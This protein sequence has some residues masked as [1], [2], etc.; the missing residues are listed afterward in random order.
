ML[1]QT[2]DGRIIDTLTGKVEGR[3]EGAPTTTSLRSGRQEQIVPEGDKVNGILR[4]A[5]WGLQS[6][7]FVAP[8]AVTLNIGKAL[9]M[10]E[11][12]VFTLGKFFKKDV[13]KALVGVEET[14]P[15]NANERFARALFE[16]IGGAMPFTG[17]VLWAA[18]AL[19]A[20]KTVSTSKTGVLRGVANETLNFTR[21]N[22]GKAVA[23]DLAFGAAY[24]GLRQAVTETISDDNPNKEAY[25]NLL[26]MAAFI[27]LPLATNFMPSVLVGKKIKQGLDTLEESTS[28]LSDA[29][30][31]AYEQ[32]GKGFKLPIINIAPKLLL[33][34]AEGKLSTMFDDVAKNQ[35]AQYGIRELEQA[36]QDPRFAEIFKFDYAQKT[37]DPMILRRYAE[38]LE[39]A[40]L[41]VRRSKIARDN[42]NSEKFYALMESIAPEA[43]ASAMEAF[44][45][46]QAEREALFN[47]V[48]Q[49]RKNLTEVEM[50]EISS[51]LGPQN[52]DMVNDEL[53]G[54]LMGAMEFDYKM[55]DNTL[56]LMG[57]RQATSPDGLPMP[58]RDG[59]KSLYPARDM[60]KAATNLIGKYTPERPSLR[61][62]V[63]EPIRLLDNFVQGQQLARN[64]VE[65]QET[66]NLIDQAFNE[67]VK[68][69]KLQNLLKGETNQERIAST[70]KVLN[71]VKDL[72]ELLVK[73]QRPGAKLSKSEKSV[74]TEW[75]RLGTRIQSDG[76][77]V[78]STGGLG[79]T[80]RFNPKQI[81][82][83]AALIASDNTA[84]NINVPEALD[85]LASAA[86]F[87]NDALAKYNSAMSKGGTRLTDAQRI[88]NTGDA[89]YNDIEK[90]IL[91][92]VPR[93][94][95]E[96]A[97]MKNVLADYRAG[98]EQNLPLL[99]AQKT[100]RGD[101]FLLGNEQLMQ[102]AFS[103][104][105][106]LRQLQVSL[107]GS[108][109][110][111]DLLMKGTIDWL[112][113]KGAVNQN[114][115]VDPKKIRSILDRNRNIVEALPDTVQSRLQNEAALA[116]D[117]VRRLGELDA[118]KVALEDDQ[119]R[120]VLAKVTR[121][122]ADPQATLI[123]ALKDPALMRSL[124]DR[125]G[126]QP[127]GLNALRR[128]IYDIAT[129]GTRGGGALQTFIQNNEKALRVLYKD[130]KHLEDLKTL[131][132]IQRR[133]FALADVT[134]KMPSFDSLEDA[135]RRVMGS[136]I[137]VLSTTY[138]SVGEGR[139]SP[140]TG[141]IAFTVRM[142]SAL[143]KN[144]ADSIFRE[145]MIDPKF[146]DSMTD[147]FTRSNLDVILKKLEKLGV[148]RTM[149]QSRVDRT[150]RQELSQFALGDQETPIPGMAEAPV[151][152]RET[153]ASMLRALPPAP[154]TTGLELLKQ[155]SA[156]PIGPPPNMR[157]GPDINLMY[158]ALFP[159]DPISG[160]LEQRRQAIQQGQ[161]M[162]PMPPQQ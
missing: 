56:R 89:V 125:L 160:M 155:S 63:P 58:T 117:Y 159:N 100:G 78:I 14:A 157:R 38:V 46:A 34:R 62:P 50:L 48:L 156:L 143:E 81:V 15:R 154:P 26:P 130:S 51:R 95:T 16:G 98:F 71:E 133:V 161:P 67:Q 153:A 10:K 142:M 118:R 162:Q 68:G 116:D 80:F 135:T 20:I 42:E 70:K 21:K 44:Q 131:A 148:S 79:D 1:L 60:E 35:D 27:G 123:A 75:Q 147:P 104:A 11:N 54:A 136:G 149:L 32:L 141:M 120:D 146:A 45:A 74:I 65:Q 145:A 152:P 113:T 124:V 90:L 103:N 84:I 64:R 22:P 83:D 108:P 109:G 107:A 57:L 12:E 41:D 13:S 61:N 31:R 77:V 158:P 73:S 134:G 102:K 93:I 86:R 3:A 18:R 138:R 2:T 43:R 96:Y 99:M 121:P 127:E 59:G 47:S 8:D 94:R 87:R 114:G 24:E 4:N 53:R 122:D 119:L 97:G 111:D 144:V 23:V 55:R 66:K 37:M 106:N 5:S 7:L 110:F 6:L 9:G 33:K 82:N 137:G 30:N 115:L 112:R 101:E 91:D 49:G 126:Q 29:S 28:G 129:E 72:L 17:T 88:L 52:M 140:Q 36:M 139:L 128:S 39:N 85:Y 132:D 40:P 105:N 25:E 151:V 76:T 150:A 92:H 69:S 19:P